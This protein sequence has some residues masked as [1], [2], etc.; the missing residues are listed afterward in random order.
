[1]KGI[2][3]KDVLIRSIKTFLEVVLTYVATAMAG[4]TYGDGTLS[5]EITVGALLS[6]GAAGIAA[7]LNGVILPLLRAE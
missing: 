7:V 5:A 3:R 2:D 4:V 1:M 6:A